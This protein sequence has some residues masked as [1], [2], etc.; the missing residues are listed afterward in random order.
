MKGPKA[1]KG[2]RPVLIVTTI[3]SFLMPFALSAVNVA[4][5]SIGRELNMHAVSLS[6]V[7]LAFTLSAG[8][9]LVPCG[10]LA[11][12]WGQTRMFIAGNW[13]FTVASFL[14]TIISTPLMLIA[15]RAMQGLGAAML[16]GTGLAIL[17]AAYPLEE[18]GRV[19][20]I[21]VASVYLGLSI[22]PFLGGVL[23]QNIGWL[24]VFFLNVPFGLLNTFMAIRWIPR[25]PGERKSGGF[26]II[27]SCIYGAML[28]LLLYGFSVIP[29][30]AAVAFIFGGMLGIV[31]FVWRE[32]RIKYPVL[33]VGLF[34]KNRSFTLSN[35]AALINYA[36]TFAVAFLLSFYLQHIK[37]FAP[38]KA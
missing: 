16:Y 25:R 7:A 24:S 28:F 4:L 34:M 26:D 1:A 9:F 32:K 23:T 31:L 6:W 21:N 19:L 38:Q 15:F 17:V 5:P 11:D 8:M 36:A 33:D 2:G 12:I 37:G 22:G 10:K 27:G 14:L 18:R 29:S 35:I 3:G 20:G 30:I 13:V